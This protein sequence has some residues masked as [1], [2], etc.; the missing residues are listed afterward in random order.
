[1]IYVIWML[2]YIIMARSMKRLKKFKQKKLWK[3]IGV[4]NAAFNF[5]VW[6]FLFRGLKK[7][8]SFQILPRKLNAANFRW[9][10]KK[11]P[12]N[13]NS[14]EIKQGHSHNSRVKRGHSDVAQAITLIYVCW[15]SR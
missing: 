8:H 4:D 3:R 6:H 13:G 2:L 15:L 10:E 11:T 12:W 1:M 14:L 9:H 7:P 5:R